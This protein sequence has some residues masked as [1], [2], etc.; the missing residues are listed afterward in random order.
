[1]AQKYYCKIFIKRQAATS[2][3]AYLRKWGVGVYK[4]R[5]SLIQLLWYFLCWQHWT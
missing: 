5:G 2:S 4:G 1:M 3:F